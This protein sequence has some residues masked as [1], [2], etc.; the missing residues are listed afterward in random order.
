[1]D[2]GIAQGEALLAALGARSDVAYLVQV[3]AFSSHIPR[4]VSKDVEQQRSFGRFVKL[5][6]DQTL[7]STEKRLARRYGDGMGCSPENHL[8]YVGPPVNP[9]I[10]LQV[11]GTDLEIVV[12][13]IPICGD[14]AVQMPSQVFES[15]VLPFVDQ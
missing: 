15:P 13:E 4:L 1:M 2:P 9:L 8:H 11:L 3:L 5:Y 14:Q 10:R 12:L 6:E 7:P